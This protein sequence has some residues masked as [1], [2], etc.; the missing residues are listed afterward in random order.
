LFHLSR[1]A[2]RK[3]IWR[4]RNWLI[5]AYLFIAVVPIALILALAV[6][7]GWVIIGQMAV[8]LVN[9]E[10]LHREAVLQ[11][12]AEILA[13]VPLRDHDAA[14]NRFVMAAGAAFPESVLRVSGHDDLR[15]PPQANVDQP[16]GELRQ[17]KQASGLIIRKEASGQR[18]Y[19]W[20][21][22]TGENGNEVTILAPITHEVLADV[23]PGLGDVYFT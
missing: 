19:A 1:L 14:I 20:A 23:M 5:A 10:L 9:T 12:Q 7:G 17:E 16:P 2:M 11:R 18:L 6:I 21:H 13:R 3:A 4:L 8:Y 22:A 15:Y